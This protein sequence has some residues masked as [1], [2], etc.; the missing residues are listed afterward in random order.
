MASQVLF[1][2]ELK[3]KL[4]LFEEPQVLRVLRRHMLKYINIE[5]LQKALQCTALG[6]AKPVVLQCIQKKERQTCSTVLAVVFVSHAHARSFLFF[7]PTN[8]IK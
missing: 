4:D 1:R 3:D 8:K 7:S 2:K 6:E 5:E